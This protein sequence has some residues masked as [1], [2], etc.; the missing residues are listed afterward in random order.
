[1]RFVLGVLLFG[2]FAIFVTPVVVVAMIAPADGSGNLMALARFAIGS[3]LVFGI[4]GYFAFPFERR[5]QAVAF[6]ALACLGY[7]SF[8]VGVLSLL[9]TSPAIL[10]DPEARAFFEGMHFR[11]GVFAAFAIVAASVFLALFRRERQA[12]KPVV[13]RRSPGP[14]RA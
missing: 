4:P 2:G 5:L 6:L 7:G 12:G 9:K 10:P 13:S 3:A 1:M 8:L 14:P 11:Y